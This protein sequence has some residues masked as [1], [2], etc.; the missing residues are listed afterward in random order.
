MRRR[1][2]KAALLLISSV[3]GLV[4]LA[5][6]Y[7]IAPPGV[8]LLVQRS[9][10]PRRSEHRWYVVGQPED[11]ADGYRLTMRRARARRETPPAAFTVVSLGKLGASIEDV[12]VV[13]L[14]GLPAR[15]LVWNLWFRGV[16]RTPVLL[17]YGP[18]EWN[19]DVVQL[20]PAPFP[21]DP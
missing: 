11:C 7:S 13:S 12:R 3:A 14:E 1:I 9:L 15:L 16:R 20:G 4:I 5:L 8:G 6:G 18:G 19:G 2:Q 10:V 17:Q 21:G